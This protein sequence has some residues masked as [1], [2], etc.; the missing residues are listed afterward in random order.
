MSNDESFDELYAKFNDIIN[1][2]YNLSEIY[3]QPKIVREILR[4]LTKDF[5]PK[6]TAITES[7]I[8]SIPVDELVGSLQSYELDL[9]K[10]S[11]SKSMALKSVDDV[12]VSG[13]NY[14][15]STTKIVY[16]TKNF[17]NFLRNN[18]RRAR[19]KNNA[20]HRN[21]RRNDPTKVNNIEKPKEKV[22]QPSNNSMG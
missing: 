6:V 4:S 10:T 18:N 12:D 8:D 14:E 5:R 3:D 19:G 16:L 17:R 13:F 11:K 15:L 20:E 22:C 7:H 9:P 2:A 1:S 21:F